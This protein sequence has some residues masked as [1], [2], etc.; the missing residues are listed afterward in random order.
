MNNPL[1]KL[2]KTNLAG[3]GI[4]FKYAE[5]KNICMVRDKLCEIIIA[6]EMM[7]SEKSQSPFT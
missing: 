6:D 3:R 2:L 4:L 5:S 7:K 1:Y